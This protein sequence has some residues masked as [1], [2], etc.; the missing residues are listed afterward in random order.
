INNSSV[1][2]V[3]VGAD[4]SRPSIPN[5]INATTHHN[6]CMWCK[7]WLYTVIHTVYSVICG[8]DKSAPYSGCTWCK[9]WCTWVNIMC[10]WNKH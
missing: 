3:G 9:R 2:S 4:S 6:G 7:R 10:S 1:H 8:H 5:C